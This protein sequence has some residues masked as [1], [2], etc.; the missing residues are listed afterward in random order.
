MTYDLGLIAWA[1]LLDDAEFPALKAATAQEGWTLRSGASIDWEQ[2][3]QSVH[4]GEVAA[5]VHQLHYGFPYVG[6]IEYTTD[7]LGTLWCRDLVKMNRVTFFPFDS[8]DGY[9]SHLYV[10][11]SWF[12]GTTY[13]PRG[14]FDSLSPARQQRIQVVFNA[15]RW[16]DELDRLE[17][18][19]EDN[20]EKRLRRY[21]TKVDWF[22]GLL[23]YLAEEAEQRQVPLD[24]QW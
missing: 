22:I 1:A 10:G 16:P 11:T 3:A 5:G 2:L 6:N 9:P 20:L 19:D 14:A 23:I 12:V 7:A 13:R 24:I 8:P 17:G 18:G 15:H 4:A 21:Q